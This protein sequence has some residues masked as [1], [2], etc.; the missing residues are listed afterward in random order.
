MPGAARAQAYP[1]KPLRW[2][3]RFP[4]GGAADIISRIMVQW[5]AQRLGQPVVVENRPWHQLEHFRA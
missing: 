5:L 2:I 1:N 4:A 3:V